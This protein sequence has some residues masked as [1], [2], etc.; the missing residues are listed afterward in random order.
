M[1]PATDWK[2]TIAPGEEAQL[3]E[4]AERLRAIQRNAPPSRPERA[5]GAR[6]TQ[7]GKRAS[8]PSS[9]SCPTCPR[10]LGRASRRAR[11]VLGVRS[12]LERR[13]RPAGPTRSR[14]CA[15]SPSRCS[16]S[17]ERKSSGPRG[18]QDPGLSPHRHPGHALPRRVRVRL[19]RHRRRQP[20]S[21]LPRVIARLGVG[22]H[23]LAAAEANRAARRPDRVAGDQE[24]LQR[25]LNPVRA[26][27][28]SLRAGAP[29]PGR[30][31]AN[32][33]TSPDSLGEELAASPP[34]RDPSCTTSSPVLR[35]RDQ[36]ANRRRL[37]GVARGRLALRHRGAAHAAVARPR[38]G[39]RAAPRSRHREA[40]VRS[41]GTPSR[42]KAARQHHARTKR[43][44]PL[45]H[46]GARRPPEPDQGA[47][48]R[49]AAG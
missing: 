33:G 43:R 24:L 8:T 6:C 40:L 49:D 1:T 23:A 16:E 29:T 27:R 13:R 5:R 15:A 21:L 20:L 10:W 26:L 41:R 25:R 32:P 46:E 31:G 3:L 14:T 42:P 48:L 18:R 37:G 36:D 39:A 19:G 4:F 7:R 12:L 44:L 2:E 38:V 34:E 35:R 45:E 11:E 17:R 47:A 22:P 9:R 28:G 30:T